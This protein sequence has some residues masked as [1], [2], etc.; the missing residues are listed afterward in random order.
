MNSRKQR[1]AS[2]PVGRLVTDRRIRAT[3]KRFAGIRRTLKRQYGADARRD[4]LGR[5]VVNGEPLEDGE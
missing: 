5:I 2:R 3:W 4:F 1:P